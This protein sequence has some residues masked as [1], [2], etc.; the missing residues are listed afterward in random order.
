M[1]QTAL[2]KRW[3]NIWTFFRLGGDGMWL[4]AD[5][6][7]K[8]GP[9][10][11]TKFEAVPVRIIDAAVTVP[12]IR[13]TR[14]LRQPARGDSDNAPQPKVAYL[15]AVQGSSGAL[16]SKPLIKWTLEAAGSEMLYA[17]ANGLNV[18]FTGVILR[19][20]VRRLRDRSYSV[21][22]VTK[23]R[24]P[25]YLLESVELSHLVEFERENKNAIG[26]IC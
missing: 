19:K 23:A 6:T 3:T 18:V 12:R 21:A 1:A 25:E 13:A 7:S 11:V 20:N 2:K 9:D 4:K 24:S 5:G 10:A 17:A 16:V 14:A 8:N 26:I 15:L 22:K